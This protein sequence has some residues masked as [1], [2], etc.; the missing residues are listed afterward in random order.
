MAAIISHS[1]TDDAVVSKARASEPFCDP[2]IRRVRLEVEERRKIGEEFNIHCQQQGLG[3]H[4]RLPQG[5][6]EQWWQSRFS[7]PITHK[8]KMFLLRCRRLAE[9]P[10]A[11]LSPVKSKEFSS[12]CKLG[13][14][15]LGD[16][17]DRSLFQWFCSI[18]GSVKG[19]IPLKLLHAQ[20]QLVRADYLGSCLRNGLIAKVLAASRAWIQRFRKRHHISLRLPNK[21][22][23]VPMVV[24]KERVRILWCNLV[25][26]RYAIFLI[27]GYWPDVDSWDQKPFHMNEAH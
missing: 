19:R 27:F 25:R 22:W 13:R 26:V 24:F 9:H 11:K 23:K 21:R 18:R 5:M 10:D 17:I 14:P 20:Y 1:K 4:K 7:R 16:S 6:M 2:A 15:V 12:T 8:E 3:L